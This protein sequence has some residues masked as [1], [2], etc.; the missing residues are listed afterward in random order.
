[1]DAPNRQP[2]ASKIDSNRPART[3]RTTRR[4]RF[5][6]TPLAAY[7]SLENHLRSERSPAPGG[8][9]RR[10]AIDRLHRARSFRP[11]VVMDETKTRPGSPGDRAQVAAEKLRALR[12]R[13]N[14]AMDEHRQ[15][16][17]Q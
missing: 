17:S 9:L 6:S 4:R 11:G 5:D 14:Q 2:S 15:R 13:A 12:Q 16:L 10:D 1:M 3:T 7:I 8:A